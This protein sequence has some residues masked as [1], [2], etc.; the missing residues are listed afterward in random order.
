MQIVK[1]YWMAL[2]MILLIGISGV[3]I[4][5]KLHSKPLPENL[6]EGTGRMDGD[7]TNLN[8]KYPGRLK[9]IYVDDGMAVKKGMV[10]AV[11]ESKEQEAQKAQITAQIA[12]QKKMLEAKKMEAKIADETIPLALEKAQEEL[13]AAESSL[14]SL[15][16][17]ISIQETIVTQAKK[18]HERSE[19]LYKSKS[20]DTHTYELSQLKVETEE[21][22]LKA[23]KSQYVG[24]NASVNL[25]KTALHEAQSSQLNLI[26][27]TMEISAM[28]SSIE[29]LEASKQQ[30]EVVLSEMRLK[31]PLEGYTVEKIANVGEV[32]GAGM[33]VVTLIDPSSLYLKIFVDTMQNGKIKV[34]DKAVIFLDA[35]PDHPIE[36]KVVHI[37]QKAEFTPKEVSVRSDRIQRVFAVHLKPLKPEFLLK[38]G[39]PAIGVVSLDGK[40]LPI[41][42]NDVPVL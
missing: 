34:G 27:I 15:K 12:A 21:K 14:E 22:K 6:V 19:F 40:G 10:V 26:K 4:W 5:K 42:L 7:L 30:I 2:L 39:I 9:H 38:L 23:L 41:S 36:A 1:K 28:A 11:L 37:A 18:D 20:I 32:I 24:A 29:A 35:Y 8:T 25:A 31:S 33:P 16:D 17:K 13:A 3:M